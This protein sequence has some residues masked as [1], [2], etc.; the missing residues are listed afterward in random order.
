MLLFNYML[1]NKDRYN[2]EREYFLIDVIKIKFKKQNKKNVLI[3]FS[4]IQSKNT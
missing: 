2:F 3:S 4:Y 1:Q